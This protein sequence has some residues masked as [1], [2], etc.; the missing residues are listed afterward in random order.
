MTKELRFDG[1]VAI[2]T[3]AGNGLGRAHALLLG[4]RGARVV[5]NDLGGSHRGEGQS[6]EAADKVVAEI[7]ARGGEA[8]AN[9]DSVENGDKIV[10]SALDHFGQ[11][12]I[13]INNAGILRDVSFA[14]MSPADWD[15][16]Y[17]VHVAGVFKTTHAA[18]GHMRDRDYGR[19]VMTSSAAGIY[20]NFGQAN[21]SMA[22]LGVF[23]FAQTLALEGRKKNV[24]V[25]TIAPIAAS[26]MTETILPPELL[27]ALRPEYVSPLVAFLC[28]ESCQETGALFEV[29]GGFIG[30]LRWERTKG[31][32]FKLSR[33]LTPEAVAADWKAI[34]SFADTT[35]PTDLNASMEPVLGNL[36]TAKGKGGNEFIDVDAAL[37]YRFP[38]SRDGYTERDLTLYA[39][40][41]GAAHNALDER[42]LRTVYENH[43]DGFVAL[44]TFG[45]IP[46]LA[47]V[48]KAGHA[49]GMNY[50]FE[51]ILHGEQYLELLRPLPTSATLTHRA[52]IKDILDKGKNAVVVT[53]VRSFDAS[54]GEV[55]RNEITTVVRGAGGWGGDRG[56]AAESVAPPDRAPDQTVTE[57]TS[58]N[59]A[60]LYRLTGDINPLH[61][62]PSFASAMGFT[63]PILHGLCTYGFAGRHVIRAFAPDGD[64][65]Y[66]RSL[67][68]RFSDSVLPGETLTTEV[69]KISATKVL[70]RTR[71]VERDVVVLSGGVAE[72]FAELPSASA[73][74]HLAPAPTAAPAAP[75][76]TDAAPGDGPTRTSFLVLQ[77][78][79]E[80]HP[81]I[82][83]KVQTVFQFKVTN[84]DA[85]WVIDLKQGK[86]YEG[87]DDRADVTLELSDADYQAMASGQANPQK[88]YFGGQ[89]K[90]GGNLMASQKLSFMQKMDREAAL[91]AAM[92]AGRVKAPGAASAPA[93]AAPARTAPAAPKEAKAPALLKALGERLAR[94]PGLGAE[95]GA[96]VQLKIREPEASWVVDGPGAAVR[97]GTDEKAATTLSIDDGDLGALLAGTESAQSLYQRGKLRIDGDMRPAQRLGVFKG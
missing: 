10:Q 13:L 68:G 80:T 63:R 24:L 58:D 71:V 69:W 62:D 18:W 55:M 95:L 8:V 57:K 74:P 5:V 59:Q 37:G 83:Q 49:P 87:T 26:R 22:K 32:S 23:G 3:G 82:A 53:E 21:Y 78:H 72:F 81:E 25:N 64:P 48:M 44:P 39:L 75:A 43:R 88:L 89:L 1:K 12:D 84:P 66:L 91:K 45:V 41:V 29:G 85:S 94:T 2:V 27:E 34:T 30:K 14:K 97:E 61:A 67:R 31:K 36:A 96:V 35:H 7:K 15:L 92:A 73:S 70:F 16:V 33:P 40:A 60:L 54:G 52:V 90:I 38:E 51:R 11:L 47:A 17:R 50:G 20:G 9:H 28:H 19:I 6:S 93:A 76:M 77:H 46:A 42:E 79:I 65:R 86:V 56:P 4:E